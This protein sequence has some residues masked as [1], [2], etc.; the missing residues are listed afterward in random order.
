MYIADSC[1]H[2]AIRKGDIRDL[3][4]AMTPNLESIIDLSPDAIL[5]SPFENANGQGSLERLGIP[6]IWCADYM[7]PSALGR[8]EWMRLYGRLFGCGERAD[9]LFAAVEAR[10]LSIKSANDQSSRTHPSVLFDGRNGSAWYMPGG[11]STLATLTRDAGGAYIFADDEGTGSVPFSFEEVYAKGHDADIWLYRYTSQTPF[12]R[13]TLRRQYKPYAEFKAFRN[14]QVYGCNNADNLFFEEYP[15][16]PER[17][18]SELTRI[19]AGDTTS[20]RYFH[21]LP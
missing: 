13:E 1:I 9:S 8:A 10:Y 19:F 14:S 16:H 11:R 12:T 7:E 4:S 18:L 3:G 2:Q 21:P 15:F 6:L 5:L 20:L 17:L